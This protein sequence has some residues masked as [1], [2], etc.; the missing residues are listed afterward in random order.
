[1]PIEPHCERFSLSNVFEIKAK[2]LSL[3]SLRIG[4]LF[5][6]V[7]ISSIWAGR[8]AL[9]LPVRLLDSAFYFSRILIGMTS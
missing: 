8:L 7:F 1:M 3:Y 4:R 5:I 6:F 2:S 9:I